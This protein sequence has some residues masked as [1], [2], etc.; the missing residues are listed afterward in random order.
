[1]TMDPEF[2]Q[3]I[4]DL[5]AS[6]LA[7]KFKKVTITKSTRL[8]KEL[9]LDSIGM[10]ALVFRFEELFSIDIAQSGADI[11]VATLHTVDDLITAGRN[12]LSKAQ[13]SRG[14]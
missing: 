9:G 13:K 1:M 10:L 6:G 4:L 5:I 14:Q 12:I 8:Q 11:N 2:D 7:G 3:Q